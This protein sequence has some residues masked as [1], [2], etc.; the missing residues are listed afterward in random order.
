MW[1]DHRGEHKNRDDAWVKSIT[2]KLG[3]KSQTIEALKGEL[4]GAI[5]AEKQRITKQSFAEEALRE[6][7]KL[8]KIEVPD[9][10]IEAEMSEREKSFTAT[11]N[12]M[13]TTEDEFCKSKGV[14]ME[15]LKE[16]WKKDSKDAVENDV[17]L[18]AYAQERDVKVGEEELEKEISIIKERAK[19]PSDKVFDNPE[20]RRYIERVAL[21][22]KAFT[23]F[24]Q[25]I[26][27]LQE[28]SPIKA[29]GKDA[30]KKPEAAESKPKKF[31]KK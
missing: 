13:K 31:S 5:S 7:V 16:Q 25:E 15:Q 11:L 28:S 18:A 29:S 14:T 6:A 20:W 1:E 9:T 26:E 27:K 19:D 22:R 30:T 21:K 23:A 2:K 8:T 12:Q 24:L 17:F 3:F 4:K 10:L